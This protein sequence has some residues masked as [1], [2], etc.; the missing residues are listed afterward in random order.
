MIAMTLP[1]LE[2]FGLR[3]LVNVFPVLIYVSKGI[4]M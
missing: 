1:D 2:R 3:L 4:Y